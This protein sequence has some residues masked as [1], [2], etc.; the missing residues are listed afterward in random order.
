[1]AEKFRIVRL[2]EN[3]IAKRRKRSRKSAQRPRRHRK[4]KPSA[5]RNGRRRGWIV[6]GLKQSGGRVA[7]VYWTGRTFSRTRKAAQ[8]YT[9]ESEAN[10]AARAS[11]RRRAA[12]YRL[13]RVLSV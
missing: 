3:P 7:F 4:R 8:I 2:K 9:H 11:M 6:E 10:K 1:M 5:A 13:A 12:S